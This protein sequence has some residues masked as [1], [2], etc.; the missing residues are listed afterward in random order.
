MQWIFVAP[1]IIDGDFEGKIKVITHSSNG[2]SVVET[3]QRCAQLVILPTV[4][5]RSQVKG[6]KGA[7]DD[8]VHQM[9]IG[10]KP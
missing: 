5:T 10:Y 9:P 3:G 2:V 4:Q 1:R 7:K 8:L 6:G